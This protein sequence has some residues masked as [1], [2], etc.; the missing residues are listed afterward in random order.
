MK[1][2][3]DGDRALSARLSVLE[4]RSET[5]AI[6]ALVRLLWR[7][8][9]DDSACSCD[10]GGDRCVLCEAW[11]ALGH[12]GKWPGAVKAGRAMSR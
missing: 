10:D 2:W 8:V 7:D 11:A 5:A 1:D 12:A 3:R 6:R 9:A 4:R